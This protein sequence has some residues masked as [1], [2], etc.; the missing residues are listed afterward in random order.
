MG[1]CASSSLAPAEAMAPVAPPTPQAATS[2][3]P[4]A[5]A[6]DP[7]DPPPVESSSAPPRA[8]SV[9]ATALGPPVVAD[10]SP[11]APHRSLIPDLPATFRRFS[12][13]RKSSLTQTRLN[14]SSSTRRVSANGVLKAILARSFRDLT[15]L[16]TDVTTESLL[17]S[18]RIARAFFDFI[19]F[20]GEEGPR[21]Y[22]MI[23]LGVKFWMAVRDL[24]KIAPGPFKVLTVI[25]IY[26]TFLQ[27]NAKQELVVLSLV[28]RQ[29]IQTK[30]D[31]DQIPETIELLNQMADDE[32]RSSVQPVFGAFVADKSPHGYTE[33][34]LAKSMLPNMQP[35]MNEKKERLEE[36]LDQSHS[37]R[38]LRDYFGRVGESPEF[39]FIVDVLEYRDSTEALITE[40]LSEE[41][42]TLHSG[43]L[44]H[45]VHKM[46]NKYLKAGSKSMIRISSTNRDMI[47]AEISC[48]DPPKLDVFDAA[49]RECSF[50]LITEHLEA[51]LS[52]PEYA[53]MKSHRASL[54]AG[55]LLHFGHALT[56]HA[57]LAASSSA[58]HIAGADRLRVEDVVK[59]A[60]APAFR[61]HLREYKMEHTLDF[62][63]EIDQFQLLPH[64]KRDYIAA[65][66]SK[67]FNKYIRRGAKMEVAL[68]GH[69]RQAILT[70][71]ADPA[72]DIFNDAHLHVLYLWDST[73]WKA[74]EK[75][76]KYMELVQLYKEE[77][78]AAATT[79]MTGGNGDVKALQMLTS[80]DVKA[81]LL[82]DG[83]LLTQ[84]HK[85]LVKENCTSYLLFY[86]QVE[87]YKRLPKS[88]FLARQSK[89]IYHRFLNSTA[90]EFVSVSDETMA[91]IHEML[92]NPSPQ[93]FHLAQEE[94]LHFLWK[95]LYPKFQK[96]IF[97]A[98]AMAKPASPILGRRTLKDGDAPPMSGRSRRF[99]PTA[100]QRTF[101]SRVSTSRT[102]TAPTIEDI[103]ANPQSRAL[104]LAFCEDIFCAESMYFWLECLEFQRIPHTDYLRLRAQKIFRKYI[105]TSAKLQVNLIHSIVRDIE[106]QMENPGRQLFAKA[107]QAIVFMLNKDTLPKFLKSK[108]YDPCCK[109]I[110]DAQS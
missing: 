12:Q 77:R 91:S 26:K 13:R 98:T 27:P 109:I 37:R 52:S 57:T 36:I 42:K 28:E 68:P 50:L 75:S 18:V 92:P 56:A 33:S 6:D 16:D 96:S 24:E 39:L 38:S 107:Q 55:G 47:L 103:L 81:I 58:T 14:S 73:L 64:N 46:Y 2:D 60:G 108:Y 17:T 8:N 10:T 65:K 34:C 78:E 66:A 29:Q 70:S 43:F 106:K 82:Q 97:F 20:K 85:F 7:S 69:I 35:F 72:E 48:M 44:M 21:E 23:E 67:I 59:G 51:F 74:F 11:E 54:L 95:T 40:S 90:K 100:V 19:H 31:D 86:M 61:M 30:L 79:L 83:P 62:Y 101:A 104:F 102:L 9:S 89:K 45:T 1:L 80:T 87:E 15:V 71:I 99:L 53:G 110:A 3:A 105:A 88:D 25:G 32:V 94:V 93:T 76:P 41:K 5:S 22:H 63:L 49:L 84:F 4:P